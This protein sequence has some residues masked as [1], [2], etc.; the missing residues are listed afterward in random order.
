M[1]CNNR[2][3]RKSLHHTKQC[4]IY[5]KKY[6][7][8]ACLQCLRGHRLH[9]SLCDFEVTVGV[10]KDLN[11][12]RRLTAVLQNLSKKYRGNGAKK[13]GAFT[14]SSPK[15]SNKRLTS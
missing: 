2:V 7:R 4:N 10:Q 8:F 6:F 15:F 9:P 5:S 13:H 11:G 3:V 1:K 14:Q 12:A